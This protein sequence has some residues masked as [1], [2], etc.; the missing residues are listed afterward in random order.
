MTVGTTY[1]V[2]LTVAPETSATAL[3]D[4]LRQTLS[5]KGSSRSPTVEQLPEDDPALI[6]TMWMDAADSSEA[7]LAA[8]EALREALRDAGLDEDAASIRDSAVRSS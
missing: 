8:G 4:V 2:F 5:A 3:R 1:E 7:R 6:V